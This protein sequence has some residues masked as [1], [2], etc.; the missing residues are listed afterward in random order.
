MHH[1]STWIGGTER[2]GGGFRSVCVTIR[3]RAVHAQAADGVGAFITDM[4]G[5]KTRTIGPHAPFGA[6]A[7]TVVG[8]TARLPCALDVPEEEIA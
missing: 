7:G 8:G 5:D 1:A 3:E 4:F 2:R 6:G